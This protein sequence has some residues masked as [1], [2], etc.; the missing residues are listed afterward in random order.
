MFLLKCL[1]L[2]I[3]IL[4]VKCDWTV[5]EYLMYINEFINNTKTYQYP[6]GSTFVNG[7]YNEKGKIKINFNVN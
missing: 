3:I 1:L 4:F 7:T 2:A 6:N 5:D